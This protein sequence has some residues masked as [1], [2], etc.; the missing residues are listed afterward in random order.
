MAHKKYVI[1]ETMGTWGIQ[2]LDDKGNYDGTP[3]LYM[4]ATE[5]EVREEAEHIIAL[6]LS[7]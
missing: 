1:V 7:I 6:I 3:C 2:W 4:G 5:D